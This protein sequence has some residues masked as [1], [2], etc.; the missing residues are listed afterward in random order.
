[1]I[2]LLH[3]RQ[4]SELVAGNTSRFLLFDAG[5]H[6][7]KA[8]GQH[9][10]A[11]RSAV[12][13]DAAHLPLKFGGTA[14]ELCTEFARKRSQTSV[15][16]LE[17]DLSHAALRG[18][19]LPGTIH[20]QTSPKIMRGLAESGTEKAMEMKFRKTGFACRLLE[21]NAGVILIG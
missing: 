18:E 10:H 5:P 16:D 2:V 6:P 13:K 4:S 1:M 9:Q 17:T 11:P 19:Q 21:Q 15:A 7:Q 14:A 20:A 3:P 12:S 8:F